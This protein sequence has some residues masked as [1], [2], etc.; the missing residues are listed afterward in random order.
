MRIFHRP[1]RGWYVRIRHG[2]REATRRAGDTKR[3]AKARVHEI[4]ALARS[5]V[6]LLEA[7]DEVLPRRGV[8]PVPAPVAGP[9][10]PTFDSL[11]Q[12]YLGILAELR[13]QEGRSTR[14][15]TENR[16][17]GHV[18]RLR[19]AP[20]AHVPLVDLS[21]VELRRW[22]ASRRVSDATARNDMSAAS[23]VLTAARQR[24]WIPEDAADPFKAAKPKRVRQK[25]RAALDADEAR[26]F[27][28][29]LRETAPVEAVR[30]IE[31]AFQ[32][33]WRLG[34]LARLRV[35]DVD[36]AYVLK[37]EQLVRA[38]VAPSREKTGQHKTAF[39]LGE[40]GAYVADRCGR[41]LPGALV[42]VQRN[43]NSWENPKRPNG[44][45]RKALGAVPVEQIPAWKR[46]GD[47]AHV[48]FTFHGIRHTANTLLLGAAVAPHVIAALLGHTLPGSTFGVYGHAHELD[49]LAAI[50]ELRGTLRGT[51]GGQAA[52]NA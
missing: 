31:A 4:E 14:A 37:G 15:W 38:H 50:R 1:A 46:K 41:A 5:G 52:E 2:D 11:A 48:A 28:A 51:G 19:A 20:W 39:F 33:G 25:Q 47:E 35:S 12:L 24:G 17:R 7:V 40:L 29:A 23:A 9:E 18:E 6:P 22:I 21:A 49:I 30:F 34:D 16:A 10:Q 8:R 32:T 13:A 45:I 36:P 44:W 3:E 43:G 26:A 42:F 27:L